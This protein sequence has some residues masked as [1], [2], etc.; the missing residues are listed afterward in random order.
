MSYRGYLQGG[1]GDCLELAVHSLGIR[2]SAPSDT[3]HQTL[4]VDEVEIRRKIGD[5]L[6]S[7]QHDRSKTQQFFQYLWTMMCV[8]RGL[9][10][11]VREV[12][13]NG[14]IQFELEEVQTGQSRLVTRPA[15]LDEELEG[16]AVQA[17]GRMLSA[18]ERVG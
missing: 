8:R 3:G 18:D 11:I 13:S 12:P 15:D 1:K 2:V 10:R 16:L 6:E 7:V 5:L 17:L 14:T 9:L 4:T